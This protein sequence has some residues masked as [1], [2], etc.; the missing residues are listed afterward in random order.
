M[1]PL[2][3]DLGVRSKA[4][5]LYKNRRFTERFPRNVCTGK[6]N[7][8]RLEIGAIKPRGQRF[9]PSQKRQPRRGRIPGPTKPRQ[10]Q[11]WMRAGKKV[12]C[13]WLTW[14]RILKLEMKQARRSVPHVR[15]SNFSVVTLLSSK[16]RLFFTFD[17]MHFVGRWVASAYLITTRS[18]NP[19]M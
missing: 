11:N 1:L 4:Q 6:N 8:Q 2:L 12:A 14:N 15:I 16:I 7:L 19:A 17:W 3:R 10:I 18:W 9:N 5:F 13:Y